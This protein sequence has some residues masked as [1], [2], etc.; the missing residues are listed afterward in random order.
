MAE[1]AAALPVGSQVP[2]TWLLTVGAM[3]HQPTPDK[4]TQ[5]GSA[6][7]AG[8]RSHGQMRA[9]ASINPRL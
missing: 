4:G 1:A 8:E 9:H 5:A 2:H 3:H 7:S 6:F